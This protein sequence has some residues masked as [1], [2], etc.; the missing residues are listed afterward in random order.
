MLKKLHTFPI[1]FESVVDQQ[2]YT[3]QFTSR[4]M[5]MSD[6]SKVSVRKSQLSGGMY[7]V[8]DDLGKPT[9]QGI[10]EDTEW[11]NYMLA[12]LEVLVV[13]KPAWWNIDEITDEKLVMSVFKEVMS[14]ENSF[15]T[16]GGGAKG[17]EGSVQGSQGASQAEHKEADGGNVPKKVVGAEVQASL[18]A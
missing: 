10:D 4:R 5:S 3:G 15:R 2:T 1:N 9:G 14:F 11:M 8:R 13:Q 6:R 7:C 18:D 17:N 16:G 12:V